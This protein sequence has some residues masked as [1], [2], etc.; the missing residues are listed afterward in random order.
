MI[1]PDDAAVLGY[2]T[3]TPQ[4]RSAAVSQILRRISDDLKSESLEW[5]LR[6]EEEKHRYHIL[7]ASSRDTRERAYALAHRVYKNCGYVSDAFGRIV[8]AHDAEPETLTLLVHD[9]HGD[10]AGTI[11]IAFDRE[12]GLP[13]DETYHAQLQEL[14]HTGR[15]LAEVT[16]LAIAPEH[17][18][19]KSVLLRMINFVYVYARRVK[20]CDDFVIEVSPRH[21]AFYNRL[22][23]FEQIGPERP[24][25]RVQ[26]AMGVLLRLEFSKTDPLISR[27]AGKG[28]GAGAGPAA[29]NKTLYPYFYSWFEEGAVAEL[30]AQHQRPMSDAD[31]AYFG[32]VPA[33]VAQ[34]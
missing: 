18:R 25:P 4:R 32:L 19:S 28:T 17:Q 3:A 1:E 21:A 2:L 13:A 12:A 29:G 30:M 6:A 9:E 10:D 26:N 27:F 24:C 14:R 22:L 31:K 8:L 11:S 33:L 16:R 7:V 34:P 5:D 23:K 15:Q 20:C